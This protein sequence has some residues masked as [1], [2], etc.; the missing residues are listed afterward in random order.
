[1]PESYAKDD[2]GFNNT[3]VHAKNS[4]RL[5]PNLVTKNADSGRF[6]KAK[7][8]IKK[9]LYGFVEGNNLKNA[10]PNSIPNS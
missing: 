9:A 1:M 7:M 6:D 5:E 3:R 8:G 10:L 2:S 4:G